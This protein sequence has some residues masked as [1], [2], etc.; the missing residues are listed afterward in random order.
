[1]TAVPP[2]SANTAVE[3]YRGRKV[4]NLNSN[5]PAALPQRVDN[6]DEAQ[7]DK[8]AREWAFIEQVRDGRTDFSGV[9]FS[10]IELKE[11]KM[12]KLNLTGCDFRNAKLL[13]CDFIST[14]L[15]RVNFTSA[16]LTDSSMTW[17]EA[18]DIAMENACLERVCLNDSKFT[19]CRFSNANLTRAFL[20]RST[21]HD[22]KFDRAMLSF[23]TFS[24]SHFVGADFSRIMNVGRGQVEDCTFRNVS[25]QDGKVLLNFWNVK[26]EDVSFHG[27]YFGGVRFSYCD[28]RGPI[29]FESCWGFDDLASCTFE[30]V[31]FLPLIAPPNMWARVSGFEKERIHYEKYRP[32]WKSVINWKDVYRRSRTLKLDLDAYAE[33]ILDLDPVTRKFLREKVTSILNEKRELATPDALE[34]FHQIKMIDDEMTEAEIQ[35]KKLASEKRERVLSSSSS[36]SKNSDLVLENVSSWSV[37]STRS[38]IALGNKSQ[39]G[40]VSPGTDKDAKFLHLFG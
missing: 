29:D 10:G 16:N 15:D 21:F 6:T 26:F 14:R 39:N 2:E 3:V 12:S 35:E 20:T 36:G 17:C 25:W 13:R 32:I 1:M 34:L 4:I 9:D 24:D 30:N 11:M 28:F 5:L 18:T 19:S 38:S 7:R 8:R 23:S 37:N 33:K 40:G 22:C 31:N 27:L